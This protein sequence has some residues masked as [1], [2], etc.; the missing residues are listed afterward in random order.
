MSICYCPSISLHLLEEA[1]I[2]LG[3]LSELMQ[4]FL[5]KGEMKQDIHIYTHAYTHKHIYYKYNFVFYLIFLQANNI[6]DSFNR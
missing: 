3:L 4:F 6:K 5:N 2:L 1:S